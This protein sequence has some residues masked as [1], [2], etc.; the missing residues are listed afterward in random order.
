MKR[1][2]VEPSGRMPGALV[3]GAAPDLD[4]PPEMCLFA[5]KL[6]P[7]IIVIF[8]ASGDLTARKLLPALFNLFLSGA[9]PAPCCIVGV[10]RTGWSREEFQNRM[11]EAI[12]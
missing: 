7:C 12:S 1:D 5:G 6:D 10:G 4:L 9:L 3:E 2:P 8:G 11:R